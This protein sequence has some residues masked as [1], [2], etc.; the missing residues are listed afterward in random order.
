MKTMRERL[1]SAIESVLD[2]LSIE[3]TDDT[4]VDEDLGL[5]SLDM[6]EVA[7]AVEDEFLV[8]APDNVLHSWKT[9]G[10]ILRWVEANAPTDEVVAKTLVRK[11]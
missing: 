7:M 11:K 10:G 8:D 6:C 5:D 9:F 4:K 1:V 3:L 2:K